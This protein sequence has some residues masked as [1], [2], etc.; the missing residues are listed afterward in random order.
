[1]RGGLLPGL[2][3]AAL[4]VA[5]MVV[6]AQELRVLDNFDDI[7]PWH[8]VASDGVSSTLRQVDGPDGRALCL[9][10]DF[11]GVSGYAVARRTLPM[12]YP[13]NYEYTLQLRGIGPANNLEFKL[14]DASGDNVW[15]VQRRDVVL[16]S[17][18]TPTKLK[19]RQ[20]AFAWGPTADKVLH[21][22]QTFEMT[23]SAGKGGKG[24]AC[25]DQLTFRA[26]PPV[27]QVPPR[28]RATATAAL[29]NGSADFAL[30][31]NPDT[32]WR[33]PKR[34]TPALVVDL[35]RER[36][37]GGLTLQWLPGRHASRYRIDLSDDGSGWR[38][39]RRVD[40]GDGGNDPI[41]LPESQ[42]RYLR[43]QLD[44]GPGG[45]FALAELR[46][47]ELA[48]AETPNAFLEAVAATKPRGWYPRGFVGEQPYWTLIGIDGGHAQGLL[49]EDGAVELARGSPSVEPFV[50]VDGRLV[51]WAD[52]QATQTLQ[53][54][55]LPIPSVHWRHAA[56]ALDITAFAQG[57]PGSSQLVARYV[58]RN[59]DSM[60]CDYTLALALRPLQ[61]NPPSQF[62]NTPG[63]VS[64]I[65]ALAFDDDVARIDGV[66]RVRMLSTADD[67]FATP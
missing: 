1:M 4:L 17:Q 27:G 53:D 43:L 12:A 47:E 11:H 39:V 44:D 41:G 18:W 31:G 48:F 57:T 51:S 38:E 63:G 59:T 6:R 32:A 54:G 67:A 50:V 28:P 42:A 5:P 52:V 45:D 66:P 58:L 36:E 16:P 2:A 55:D 15:W 8:A 13:A 25:I 33:A 21:A 19:Q 56:F 20:I 14:G 62:L 61:V 10:Y 34:D 26:L 49:G 23:I 46:I 64:P 3:L 60:P 40:V 24:E 29:P 22:S 37:F 9:D 35:G 65:K 7:A 30:D